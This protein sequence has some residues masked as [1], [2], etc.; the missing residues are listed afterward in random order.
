MTNT[1]KEEILR[2]YRTGTMS[3]AEIGR[4]VNAKYPAVIRFIRRNKPKE[5]KPER[6]NAD[7]KQE[8]L[9]LRGFY[10]RHMKQ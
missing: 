2:L 3:Y 5:E 6:G 8:L 1:Q 7:E 9:F 10:I 4:R